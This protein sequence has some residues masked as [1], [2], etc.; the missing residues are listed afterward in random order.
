MGRNQKRLCLSL[1]KCKKLLKGE[2]RKI[3]NILGK[4]VELLKKFKDSDE[5]FSR[6]DLSRSNIYFKIR[7]YKFPTLK[8]S[9]L[10]SSNFKS[11]FKFITKVYKA[12]VD[13]FGEK[14]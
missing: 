14:K 10:I 2:N 5:F 7:L 13:I 4:Q 12:N 9:T 3:I 1:K 8:K 11:N 6:V